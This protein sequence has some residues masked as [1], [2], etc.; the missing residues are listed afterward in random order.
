MTL[1]G[2]SVPA[3]RAFLEA[4]QAAGV[5]TAPVEA[6]PDWDG[7]TRT[8]YLRHDVDLHIPGIELIAEVEASLGIA[9]TFFVPLTLHFNPAF[10]PNREVLR[11]LLRAGHRIGLH[12]D[13]QTYPWDLDQAWAHLDREV[14]QLERDRRGAGRVDLHALPVGRPRRRLPTSDRYVHP[15]AFDDVVYVSDSCRAWRDENLLGILDPDGPGAPAAQH[16]SRS[17]GWGRRART[18]TTSCAGRCSTTPSPS[19]RATCSTTWSRPGAP[20]PLR[21]CTTHDDHRQRHPRLPRPAAVGR[22]PVVARPAS[23]DRATPDSFTFCNREPRP[24]DAALVLTEVFGDFGPARVAVVPNARLAFVRAVA[25]FFPP[26]LPP[27]GVHPTAVVADTA[28]LG[29][30][31]RIGPGC[32]LGEDVVV[33]DNVVLHPGVHVLRGVRIGRGVV[34]HAGTVIGADGYGFERDERGALVRF[35]HVGGV[36]IEDGVEI[37]ANACIDRGALDNT[38]IERGARV[39]NLVHVAHNVRIGRDAAVIANAMLGGS[40]R[41]GA[42]A[43]IAPSAVLRDGVTIG[44]DALVGLGAVVTKDVEPGAV[45]MG[46]PAR[47]R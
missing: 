44:D 41:V 47:P 25:H 18:A 7:A 31:V 29:R 40:S 2:F 11:G 8:L 26:P 10:P 36:V 32:T 15:H 20:T 4:V 39:D 19:T 30:D 23:L 16:P 21:P 35:P 12:Y 13:L 33:G 38:V 34:V 42:R 22:R 1:P 45:V 6:M 28:T 27:A 46:N 14:E 24:T 9:A 3:Y 5:V 43:W 37:G 17:C